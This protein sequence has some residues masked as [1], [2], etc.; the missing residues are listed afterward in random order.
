MCYVSV[1]ETRDNEAG[2]WGGRKSQANGSIIPSGNQRLGIPR[3]PEND[4]DHS[5]NQCPEP[6][7][8]C[9]TSKRELVKV[10]NFWVSRGGRPGRSALGPKGEGGP[11]LAGGPM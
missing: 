2:R 6:E 4:C 11:W 7:N 5:R 3:A 10:G 8:P 9:P 1:W